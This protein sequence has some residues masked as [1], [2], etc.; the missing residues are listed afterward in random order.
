MSKMKMKITNLIWTLV[1][2]LAVCS[3]NNTKYLPA[4]ESLYIG[5]EV[6]VQAPGLKKK[7]KKLLAKQLEALTRPRPN[8]SILGLRPKLWFW[9]I[10]GTPKRK[11]SIKRLLKNMGEEPVVLSDLNLKRNNEVLQSN[12]QNIGFF[13]AQVTGEVKIKNRRAKAIYTAVPGAE[14]TINN[15]DFPKDSTPLNRDIARTARRTLL[16]KKSPFNL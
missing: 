2:A 10:G 14:Y 16:K 12:L 1:I 5:A 7:K 9:N 3:C 11:I 6:K 15:V 8:A 13:R 4:N